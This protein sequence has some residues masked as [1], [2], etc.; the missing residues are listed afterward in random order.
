MFDVGCVYCE[1]R[2]MLWFGCCY[3][4]SCSVFVSD[5]IVV[6]D[7]NVV[8]NRCLWMIGFGL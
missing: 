6:C 4:S 3:V 1:V 5:S 2:W 8:V 7:L